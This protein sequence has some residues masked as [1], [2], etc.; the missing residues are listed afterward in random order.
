MLVTKVIV[1][2]TV[3]ALIVFASMILHE[4][5]HYI[6]ARL[7][8][9]KGSI[10]IFSRKHVLWGLRLELEK[11]GKIQNLSELERDDRIRYIIIALAPYWLLIYGLILIYYSNSMTYIYAGYV[12]FVF[13]LVNLPLEFINF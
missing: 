2:F 4:L 12:I 9:E 6:A 7:L 11:Y 1:E 3:Y 8:K 10:R 5:S 13:H